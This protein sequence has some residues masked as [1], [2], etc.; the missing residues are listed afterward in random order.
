MRPIAVLSAAVV[1]LILGTVGYQQLAGQHYGVAD[2]L[3]RALTLFALAGVVDAPVPWPLQVARILAP[4]ITG[5]AA[6]RSLIRLSQEQFQLLGIRLFARAPQRTQKCPDGTSCSQLGHLTIGNRPH[7]RCV[8]TYRFSVIASAMSM[9][10]ASSQPPHR[11]RPL[12][13]R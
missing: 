1:V 5:Y 6:A 13:T 2:S 4:M 10:R 9:R 8:G 7:S 12:A 3:Y 11:R